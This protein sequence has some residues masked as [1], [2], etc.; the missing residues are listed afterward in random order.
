VGRK[1]QNSLSSLPNATLGM[2]RQRSDLLI[3]YVFDIAV[4]HGG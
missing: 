2:R 1:D 3:S 4:K